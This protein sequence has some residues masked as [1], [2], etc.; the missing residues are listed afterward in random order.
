VR[1]QVAFTRLAAGSSVPLLPNGASGTRRADAARI[2]N[3]AV[4]LGGPHSPF[5][6][7]T[8]SRPEREADETCRGERG[9]NDLTERM[10]SSQRGRDQLPNCANLL[11]DIFEAPPG[12]EP[13]DGGF[14]DWAG[15][16][17]LLTR[18][19]LWSTLLPCPS[20]C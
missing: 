18:L 13:G 12:F 3:E 11:K 8:R 10:R 19:A 6:P 4:P 14:A 5:P 9:Q 20:P 7:R 15:V 1:L 2:G 17:N 16:A